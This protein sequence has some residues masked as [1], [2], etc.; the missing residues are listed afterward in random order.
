MQLIPSRHWNSWLLQWFVTLGEDEGQSCIQNTSDLIRENELIIFVT[1]SSA[2]LGQSMSPSHFHLLGTQALSPQLKLWSGGQVAFGQWSP[3]SE[4]SPQSFSPSQ[5]HRFWMQRPLAH[6][7]SSSV[8]LA[9]AGNGEE[10]SQ[11]SSLFDQRAEEFASVISRCLPDDKSAAS[12]F[13]F[14]RQQEILNFPSSQLEMR[15][16]LMTSL[17]TRVKLFA[18]RQSNSTCQS[19]NHSV[20]AVSFAFST[21]GIVYHPFKKIKGKK[22]SASLFI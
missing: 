21:D 4:L 10:P 1:V 15:L 2:P 8:Q 17:S 5:N 6:V 12:Y 13:H 22:A 9:S 16:A 14:N 19:V 11:L 18:S 7:N 20:S 3:S